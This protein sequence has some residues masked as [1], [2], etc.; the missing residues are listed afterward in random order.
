M[1]GPVENPFQDMVDLS[2]F[3]GISSKP[4]GGPGSCKRTHAP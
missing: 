3:T 4:E 1:V 2:L